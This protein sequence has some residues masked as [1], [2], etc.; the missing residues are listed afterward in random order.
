M[1]L[2]SKSLKT[3]YYPMKAS[4]PHAT[5]LWVNSRKY[6]RISAWV[7]RHAPGCPHHRRGSFV[8]RTYISAVPPAQQIIHFLEEK[9]NSRKFKNSLSLW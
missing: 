2:C 4:D 9:V 7:V 1:S 5:S 8:W 6:L 3:T